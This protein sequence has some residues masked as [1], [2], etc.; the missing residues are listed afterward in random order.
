MTDIE[1]VLIDAGCDP[2]ALPDKEV[3][4]WQHVW[5]RVYAGTIHAETGKWMLGP[6]DWHVFSFDKCVHKAGERAR[7][8]YRRVEPGPFLVLSAYIHDTF[9]FTC[10]GQPPDSLDIGIDILVAPPSMEW[11]MAFNHERY[12]PYFGVAQ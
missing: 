9:G 2:V 11:T 8:A 10:T 1:T 3:W 4:S 12:G 5:R 6:F 7:S